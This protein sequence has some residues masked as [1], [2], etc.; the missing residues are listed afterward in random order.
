MSKGQKLLVSIWPVDH[1][2]LAVSPGETPRVWAR[3]CHQD[4]SVWGVVA[5]SQCVLVGLHTF[6]GAKRT[7]RCHQLRGNPNENCRLEWENNGSSS[8]DGC[9]LV[10]SS[11][12]TWLGGKSSIKK[13][14]FHFMKNKG[15][16]G[17]STR[18]TWLSSNAHDWLPDVVSQFWDGL[19][20]AFHVLGSDRP[21]W[22]NQLLKGALYLPSHR[23]SNALGYSPAPSPLRN[24][25]EYYRV[26]KYKYWYRL[27]VVDVW[28]TTYDWCGQNALQQKGQEHMPLKTCWSNWVWAYGDMILLETKY[29]KLKRV[30]VKVCW[31][32]PL[33]SFIPGL[34]CQYCMTPT[35][36][37]TGLANI[38]PQRT[39]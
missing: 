35:W 2:H 23:S 8:K 11:I 27:L 6:C 14:S 13:G 15:H 39:P 20:S 34:S 30:S 25:I 16:K 3:T 22:F 38:C 10:F 1:W 33:G 36:Y 37:N 24:F 5:K 7:T 18:N 9:F 29:Q 19:P 21:V 17:T 28:L 4:T 31:S 26:S 32:S 12:K